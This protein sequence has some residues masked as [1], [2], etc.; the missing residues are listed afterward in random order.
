MLGE[1][2]KIVGIERNVLDGMVAVNVDELGDLGAL[3][4]ID[5]FDQRDAKVAKVNA[6]DFHAGVRV[7]GAHIV[8]PIDELAAFHLDVEPCPPLD[9]PCRT[10]VGDVVNL[11]QTRHE[12]IPLLLDQMHKKFGNFETK[13]RCVTV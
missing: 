1:L 8:D 13:R 2:V 9:A 3:C 10:G 6:P 11:L 7:V 4:S 12:C 5:P